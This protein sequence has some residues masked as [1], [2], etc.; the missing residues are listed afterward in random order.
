MR[1]LLGFLLLL[2]VLIL[3]YLYGG[4]LY[5]L[6]SD[7]NLLEDYLAERGVL[8]PLLFVLLMAVQVVIAPLPGSLIGLAGGY[9][10]GALRGF[11]LNM[12]GYSLGAGIAFSLSRYFGKPLVE[13]LLGKRYEF[14]LHKI[15][16]RR[17]IMIVS[18]TM[19]IPF[20]P[21]DA[22]CFLAALTP[23]PFALFMVLVLIFRTPALL[24]AGLIGAG[25]IRFSGET[26]GV[27]AFGGGLVSLLVWHYRQELRAFSRK[28]LDF[29]DAY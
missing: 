9:A 16:G 24:M 20:A 3:G 22:I 11:V 28:V 7:R 21:D 18:A 25:F 12:L 10:F 2:V 17:G 27:L 13:R 6:V 29:I 4:S 14:L 23:I 19:L 15:R 5:H 1:V 8:A 26:W